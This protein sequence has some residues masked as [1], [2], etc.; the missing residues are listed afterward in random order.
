MTLSVPSVSSLECLRL[1]L[2][3]F[4]SLPPS[5]SS[6]H[7]LKINR[8]LRTLLWLSSRSSV[9]LHVSSCSSWWLPPPVLQPEW[10]GLSPPRCR[11]AV[12]ATIRR[13]L[14][15][16]VLVRLHWGDV[17]SPGSRV[18]G[19]TPCVTLWPAD[20]AHPPPRFNANPRIFS[21]PHLLSCFFKAFRTK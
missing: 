3:L 14:G 9:S 12:A 15:D 21:S 16:I 6:S 11:E 4:P 13:L 10:E 19:R 5:P 2:P 20:R 7:S 8:A 17:T 18:A 1:S